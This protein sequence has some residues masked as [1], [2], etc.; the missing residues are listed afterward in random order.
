MGSNSCANYMQTY[1][2]FED[3]PMNF[4]GSIT[5]FVMSLPDIPVALN[6]C[7]SEFFCSV[8]PN[9]EEIILE[10][11][12]EYEDSWSNEISYNPAYWIETLDNFISFIK[13]INEDFKNVNN[14]KGFLYLCSKLLFGAAFFHKRGVLESPAYAYREIYKITNRLLESGIINEPT[15]YI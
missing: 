10:N 11:I 15:W 4:A 12:I 6:S 3:E 13:P 5:T 2:L 14:M 9:Y 7:K 1:Y 8:F